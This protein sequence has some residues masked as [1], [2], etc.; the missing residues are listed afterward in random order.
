MYH[1]T[2]PSLATPISSDQTSINWGGYSAVT[3]PHQYTSAR[4][5]FSV[6][7][8][9]CSPGENSWASQ[10][11]GLDGYG[12]STVE[13]TGVDEGCFNGSPEYIA[14]YEVYPYMPIDYQN[15]FPQPGDV[16]TSAVN[17]I[18][19][20][21][22]SLSLTDSTNGQQQ[23]VVAA[24]PGAINGGAECIGEDPGI[25][26]AQYSDFSPVTFTDCTANGAP[27]GQWNPYKINTVASTG[28]PLAIVSG[29]TNGTSF[30]ITRQGAAAVPTPFASTVTSITPTTD[31]GGYWIAS[32]TGKVNQYG[33]A[34]VHGSAS[35]PLNRPIVDIKRTADGGGYWMVATDGGIFTY[36]DAGFYGSTGGIHLNQPIVGMA[37]TPDGKGYWLVASDGGIFSFGD[38][39][40]YGS[41]G[42]MHLNRP[43]VGMAATPD[44]KG[45]WLV[46]SDG[47]IFSFGDA[48]FHGSTGGIVLNRPVVGMAAT[49][50]GKGY[51]LVAS[52][53]GIF[54]FGDAQFHGSTGGIVLN[55]P[56]VDIASTPDG[57]GYWLVAS[58]GGIFSFGDANFYGSGA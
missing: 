46:A 50:D 15:V 1:G 44:G 24:V 30:T 6:P 17:W 11:A 19:G 39:Q 47:G 55:K 43:I 33:D 5:T 53:G 58:D 18:S 41:T 42:G 22:Y 25:P 54:S 21:T 8:I 4:G 32:T 37:P 27:I 16:I 34:V 52:D 45:Y 2:Q 29:L 20:T 12:T 14:W 31:G 57:G 56:I 3:A 26:Q 28:T 10:W 9:T 48:Q 36:G 38:A 13:Q 51:W 23:S 49:P 7:L 40:F 35:G